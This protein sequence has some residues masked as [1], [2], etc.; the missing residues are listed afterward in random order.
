MAGHQVTIWNGHVQ[1]PDALAE[2][3][4]EAEALVLIRE[5]TR[6]RAPLLERLPKLRLISRRSVWPHIDVDA[7]TR[8]GVLLCSNQHADTPS[9]AT[10][11]MTWALVLAAMRRLPQQV[12]SLRAGNWQCG[13]GRTLRGKTLGL[14]GHGRIG[15]AVAEYGRAFGMRVLVLAREA[16]MGR[17][18]AKGRETAPDRESFFAGCD[19]ISLHMRLVEATRHIVTA[20]DLARMKPD[21]LLVNTSGRH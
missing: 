15:G 12:A 13:V 2:W 9:C 18:R 10:A 3:L 8:R 4:R 14:Y 11:A 1:E 20:A 5:R 21:A 7:C 16:S 19:V 6:I 17:A